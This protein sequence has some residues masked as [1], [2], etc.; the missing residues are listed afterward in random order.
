VLPN[1][2]LGRVLPSGHLL[3]VRANTLVVQPINPATLELSGGTTVVADNLTTSGSFSYAVNVAVSRNGSLTYMTAPGQLRQPVWLDRVTGRETPLGAPAKAYVYPTVSPDG[4]HIAF[5]VHENAYSNWVWSVPGQTLTRITT[6][7]E[8]PRYAIWSADSRRLIYSMTE[9]M[10]R[11]KLIARAVDGS[12]R[13]EELSPRVANLYPLTASPDGRF[14]VFKQGPAAQFGLQALSLADRSI[15]SILEFNGQSAN[16]AEIS[17]DGR[18]IVHQESSAG[19]ASIV[20]RPFPN[21][22]GGRWVVSQSGSKPL[23]SR[24]GRELFF[25]TRDLSQIATVP[26][27][28]GPAFTFSRAKEVVDVRR[29][30]VAL[31]PGSG[32]VGRTYDVSPDG[33]RFLVFAPVDN[34]RE[35][36]VVVDHWMSELNPRSK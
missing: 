7:A 24:N 21:V 33:Q 29:F 2:R 3:Y 14:L 18:W 20:V 32:D 10:G 30:Q 27:G 16:T 17:P 5:N 8:D 1:V 25:L 13:P 11:R 19:S 35:E 26:I 34:K 22:D 36:I 6:E 15:S 4:L 23:W 31:Q 12:G 9:G 28:A